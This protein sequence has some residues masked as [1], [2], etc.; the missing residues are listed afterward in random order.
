MARPAAF[1]S[2]LA[3]YTVAPGVMIAAAALI[4]CTPDTGQGTESDPGSP[5]NQQNES[6]MSDTTLIIKS[7]R[8]IL[9]AR[10]A[11]NEATRA[12][13]KM[14]PLKLQ[15][16]D[17]LRQEKPAPLP[18]TLPQGD[19]QTAFSAGTLGLWGGRDLVIYYRQG[20]D[21][22][23]GIVMLGKLTGDLSRLDNGESLVVSF[24]RAP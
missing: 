1:W 18:A 10:L 9:T 20:Q 16:R 19:R 15:M 22:H 7:D 5:A 24:R 14:L 13:V 4:G 6:V 17:H 11:D 3:R 2:N 23:P 21:P 8:G 12:L